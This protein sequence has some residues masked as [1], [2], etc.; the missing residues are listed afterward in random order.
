M[1]GSESKLGSVYLTSETDLNPSP[2]RKL[3]KRK[4][5]ANR[6]EYFIGFIDQVVNH[7]EGATVGGS[8]RMDPGSSGKNYR[9][10]NTT[11]KNKVTI[12]EIDELENA[13]DLLFGE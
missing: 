8:G 10:A 13:M 7:K 6:Q 9:Q 2:D 1:S 3:Q 4:T 5:T 12:N 11:Q